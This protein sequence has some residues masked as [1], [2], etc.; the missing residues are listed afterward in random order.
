MLIHSQNAHTHWY[1]FAHFQRVYVCM[2]V[3]VLSL[4]LIHIHTSTIITHTRKSIAS[5]YSYQNKDAPNDVPFHSSKIISIW[6]T[7]C[8]DNWLDLWWFGDELNRKQ[9]VKDNEVRGTVN[10]GRRFVKWTKIRLDQSMNS[11]EYMSQ[12]E[13]YLMAIHFD[14]THYAVVL[15][16]R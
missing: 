12:I 2:C 9:R 1:T 7:H 5:S 14:Y 8:L 16:E 10:I 6:I 15:H 13:S 11:A 4:S 3:S